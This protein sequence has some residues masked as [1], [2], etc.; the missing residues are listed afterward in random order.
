MIG[1]ETTS[2]SGRYWTVLGVAAVLPMIASTVW[3]IVFGEAWLRLRGIDPDTA[4][5]T[6][7]AW[8]L[9]GQF[10]RNLVVVVVL[11]SLMRRLGVTTVAAALRLGLLVWFGFEAMAIVGAVLHEGYPLG[12]YAIHTGD[13]LLAML[14]VTLVLGTYRR[15]SAAGAGQRGDA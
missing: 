2:K 10:V 5:T 12:L 11:A 15:R 3:Y 7:A 14:V 8:A 9:V 6:P 13:A 1:S 4:D